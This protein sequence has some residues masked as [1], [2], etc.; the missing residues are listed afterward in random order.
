MAP[1]RGAWPAPGIRDSH[2][3]YNRQVLRCPG[4]IEAPAAQR[5]RTQHPDPTHR[6]DAVEDSMSDAHAQHHHD[7]DGPHEGPI[8]TPKQLILAVF[9]AF[10]VPIL[11]IIL[12]VM[13]VSAH[14][15]PAAGSDG[16]TEKA[17]AERLRPIGMVEV[18]DVSDPSALKTGE[19]VY[20]AVCV[21]CHTPGTLNAPKLGD[22]AAWAPRIAQGYEAL[23]AAALKGKGAMP[24]QGGGDFTDL[25]IGRAVVH[26][27]N[28]SGGK[29]AEPKVTLQP[30]TAAAPAT[31]APATA[32]TT[33]SQPTNSAAVNPTAPAAVTTAATVAAPAA[34]AA[35]PALY[36]Q[37]CAACHATGVANAPKLGDKAG[38][39][40]RLG[41]GVDG[42]TASAIKGKGAMP[43]KGG[44]NASDADIK[45]VVA[46]MVNQVK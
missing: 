21:A 42:L 46:Y 32:A 11:A 6:L 39:A 12:L 4:L 27:A 35:V 41:Q 26:L 37:N 1:R 3:L 40:P 45:A 34:A 9:F 5:L 36:T 31:P 16:L 30:A 24:A 17:V 44:A 7:E 8:K 29:F 10:V 22:T 19:Q 2:A 20:A 25:E 13:Y 18:K 23:L 38:W 14:N 43:P 33:T 28:K 15:R